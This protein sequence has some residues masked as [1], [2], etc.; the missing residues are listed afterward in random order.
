MQWWPLNPWG[1][2]CDGGTWASSPNLGSKWTRVNWLTWDKYFFSQHF[3]V[4]DDLPQMGWWWMLSSVFTAVCEGQ[5]LVC[6]LQSPLLPPYSNPFYP[7]IMLHEWWS[8]SLLEIVS[9][10]PTPSLGLPRLLSGKGSAC[11]GRSRKRCKSD[12]WFGKIPWK[13]K[14]QPTPVFLPGKSIGQKSLLGY[15]HRVT[16]SQT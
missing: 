14:W 5:D 9:G 12:P 1:L 2:Q 7:Q 6:S 4:N 15:G 16:K 8:L 10:I 3:K 13:R 11:Q